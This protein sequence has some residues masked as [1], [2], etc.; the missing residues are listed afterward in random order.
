LKETPQNSFAWEVQ[1]LLVATDALRA[2]E[3]NS[4][5]LGAQLAPADAAKAQGLTL[6]QW[7]RVSALRQSLDGDKVE[8]DGQDLPQDLRLYLAGAVDYAAANQACKGSADSDPPAP[9]AAAPYCSPDEA[10]MAGALSRFEKVLALPP[11]QATLRSV[12]AAYMAGTIHAQRANVAATDPATFKREREAAASMFQLARARSL[13]GA[14]DTEGLA[15]ASFGEEARLYLYNGTHQCSWAELYIQDSACGAAIAAPDLK[16]AITLYAAQAGHGSL[17]AV[18]SLST[19]ADN[20]LRDRERIA[21][22]IDAPVSQR[23]LIADVLAGNDASSSSDEASPAGAPGKVAPLSALVAAI[24]QQGLDHV[25]SADRLAALAYQA[26]RYD[27][28]ATLA[29]RTR[30]PLAS[31]VTAKLALHRGDLAAAAAAYAEAAGAFP[32]SDDPKASVEPASV[33]LITGEQGVLALARGEYVEAMG[34]LYAAAA[35]DMGDDN[36]FDENSRSDIS[37]ANDAAYVAERV[38]TLDEL[39]GFVDAHAA[40]TPAPAL[41]TEKDHQYPPAPFADN[42]RWLLARRLMRAGRYDEAQAYFPASGDP[43]FGEVDLRAKARDYASFLHAA[44]SAWSDVGKAQAHYAA[45]AITRESGMELFGY[46]QAPDYNDN[47]GSYPGGS[48]HLAQALKQSF[49]TDGERQRFAESAAKPDI[50]FH[51]R[52]VAADQASV[53]ADLLPP[54]SQAFAAVLC[55]ATGWMQQGPPP[56]NSDES[57]PGSDAQPPPTERERRAAAY[58]QRYVKQG[59]HVSWAKDF[60]SSCAEPDFASARWLPQRQH[61]ARA[62]HLIRHHPV[63]AIGAGVLLFGGLAGGLWQ[64]RRRNRANP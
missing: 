63:Y 52:Y 32:K 3:L 31:W 55:K 11:A 27:L 42:L 5:S 29:A 35:R 54:R 47:G 18:N 2:R 25:A 26:G 60:G 56:D 53:A 23:L 28:A 6:A 33:N 17:S 57:T 45:A 48:G 21:A 16:R 19:I 41:V 14:S 38:L 43:R 46:E 10:G 50:R 36:A 22:M 37:Y 8:A 1:H 13:A 44:D 4:Y 64:R 62:E 12:W 51:Y 24:E 7:Q 34:H 59:A 58:Y 9:A 40:A 49:V 39:K 30:G 61:I 15:V 20:V